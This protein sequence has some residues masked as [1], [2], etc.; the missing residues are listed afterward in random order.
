M[1]DVLDVACGTG[2]VARTAADLVGPTGTVVGLDVNEAMLTVAG[3]VRPDIEWRQG[4]AAALPFADG[5]FDA[6][7]CQ[8][9]L[10]FFADRPTAHRRD[11]A[12]RVAAAARW[13]SSSP[14]P[15]TTRLTFRPFVELAGRI[16]GPEAMSLLRRTSC[17]GISV[18]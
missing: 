5:A 2:I 16:A 3:R 9:A 8:M 15:S 6:V 17:A 7:L 12:G 14:A 10:M 18:S 13:R 1:H 11:G 4:D